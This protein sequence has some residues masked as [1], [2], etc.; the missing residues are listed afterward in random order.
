MSPYLLLLSTVHI[1]KSVDNYFFST[2]F[3]L[4]S[5]HYN[6][7]STKIMCHVWIL[8]HHLAIMPVKLCWC[9][10]DCRP[11]V[12][13]PECFVIYQRA[14]AC[15]ALCPH[16]HKFII[17]MRP[18]TQTLIIKWYHVETPSFNPWSAAMY[19]LHIHKPGVIKLPTLQG[20]CFWSWS[21]FCQYVITVVEQHQN[22]RHWQDPVPKWWAIKW[23]SRFDD[24]KM[25]VP[26]CCSLYTG[27]HDFRTLAIH[28]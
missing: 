20:D 25:E 12:K 28:S 21:F 10:E 6:S 8:Y 27:W 14:A 16:L 22:I 1:H 23:W 24:I 15:C 3:I 13:F 19:S 11:L 9:S 17:C 4:S 2:R 7:H 26:I 18:I 5:Y